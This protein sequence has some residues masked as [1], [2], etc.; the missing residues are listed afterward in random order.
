M[1][2][3]LAVA[4]IAGASLF[5]S[6]AVLAA[7]PT[8]EQAFV[9]AYKAAYDAKDAG[10]IKKFLNAK[11]AIPLG[12]QLM[13]LMLTSEFGGKLAV[14]E[15]RELSPED[16]K[17]VSE[18][19]AMPDGSKARLLPTPYKKLVIQVEAEKA[20]SVTTSTT[21][22]FLAE[23]GGKLVIATPAPAK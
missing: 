19:Q 20:E 3:V 5:A 22:V 13:G 11:G 8:Q 6:H 9:D 7:T 18:V 16:V 10:A 14:I 1:N 4:A 15:L 21:E 23:A 17:A 12:L 2:K